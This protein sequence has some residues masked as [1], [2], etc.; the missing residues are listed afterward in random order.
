MIEGDS[1][2]LGRSLGTAEGTCLSRG[3]WVV[4]GETRSPAPSRRRDGGQ[5]AQA[6][7]W[8]E[9]QAAFVAEGPTVPPPPL[10]VG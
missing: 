9:R 10:P 7:L 4:L 5:V 2:S 3:R 6:P 8:C 1:L